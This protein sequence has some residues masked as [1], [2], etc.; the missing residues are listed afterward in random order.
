MEGIP[1]GKRVEKKVT[2]SGRAAVSFIAALS[3]FLSMIGCKTEEKTVENAS[4]PVETIVVGCDVYPPF[5]YTSE[6]GRPT[7]ID[8]DLATE[9]FRRMGYE[10]EFKSIDWENKKNL[11]E[12][13]EIDCIWSCFSMAGRGDEYNW[14]G[15]YMVSRQVVAVMPE[16][17]IWSLDD[18]EGKV[19]AVQVTTKPEEL[20]LGEDPDLPNLKYLFSLQN[21]ELIYPMLSKGYVDAVAAHETSIDQ[22]MSDYDVS[23]RILDEPLLTVGLGVAFAKTDKRGLDRKLTETLDE[24]REDGTSKAIVSKYLDNPDGYLELDELKDESNEMQTDEEHG[25]QGSIQMAGE[26]DRDGEKES[27]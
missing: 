4:V 26:G 14:A 24:M 11:V 25:E 13:G 27:E 20:F 19:L 5:N 1:E 23:Y 17:D 21:R 9:A 6:S 8:I 2:K 3:A 18:L 22:Y 15:P 16:S 10:P 12:S 7:G